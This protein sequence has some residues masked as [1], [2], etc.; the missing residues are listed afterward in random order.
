MSSPPKYVLGT[1]EAEIARLDA[2][3]ASIAPAT[4]L[5]LRAAGLGG[6]VR[7]LDLGTGLGHVAFQ[8]AALLGGDGSVVG[9]DEA[10][11]L[12]EVAERRRT[13]EGRGNVRFVRGDA[14]TYRDDEPFDAI[15][16]RLLLF[17]L[18][19]AVDVVRHWLSALRPG[20]LV[21]AIDFD[22]GAARTEPTTPLAATALG[23]VESAFRAA[24]AN[25]R[26]GAQLNQ[27]L[28]AA[29]VVDLTSFGV[30]PYMA[31]DDP[32][33]PRLLGGVVRTLAPQIV[34]AGIA[35]EAELGLETLERRIASELT[36]AEAVFLPPAVAGAWGH[37]ASPP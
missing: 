13:A 8:V 19:D 25:P 32:R 1:A 34:S 10:A 2:Q 11:P 18:P 5:L 26:I 33:G 31:P 12:L 29:G 37:R 15:V 20:G 6:A 4:D 9:V 30:Q 24:G 27:L 21:L 7:V 22:L 28:R 14:R 35:T 36:T 16:T 3:A 23:W 17:H